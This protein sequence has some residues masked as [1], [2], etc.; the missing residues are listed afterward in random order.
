LK[1]QLAPER[2]RVPVRNK[3]SEIEAGGSVI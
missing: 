3:R 2:I 1:K